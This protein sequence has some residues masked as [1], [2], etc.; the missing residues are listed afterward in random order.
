[1]AAIET[2]YALLDRLHKVESLE[3]TDEPTLRQASSVVEEYRITEERLPHSVKAER[4][5]RNLQTI[6]QVFEVTH[7]P[8]ARPAKLRTHH[9]FIEMR[10]NFDDPEHP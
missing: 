7:S 3:L 6:E 5:K 4:P 1:M 8:A 9:P 2:I 10:E